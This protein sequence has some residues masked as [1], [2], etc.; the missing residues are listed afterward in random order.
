MHAAGATKVEYPL[1]VHPLSGEPLLD[2]ADP[3]TGDD[4]PRSLELPQDPRQGPD[5]ITQK[6][7]PA[8]RRVAIVLGTKHVYR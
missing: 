7:C 8:L 5:G 6:C 4:P 2:P 1:L 3:R